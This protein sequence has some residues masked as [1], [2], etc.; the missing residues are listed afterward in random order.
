MKKFSSSAKEARVSSSLKPVCPLREKCTETDQMHWLTY[1]HRLSDSAR[2]RE[3]KVAAKRALE[4]EKELAMLK[5]KKSA[6]AKFVEDTEERSKSA[7]E[8]MEKVR[9]GYVREKAITVSG[10]TAVEMIKDVARLRQTKAKLEENGKRKSKNHRHRNGNGYVTGGNSQSAGFP[11]PSL[12]LG[13]IEQESNGERTKGS[14]GPRSASTS[15][16]PG[17]E[18]GLILDEERWSKRKKKQERI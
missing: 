5:G 10:S 3:R 1:S 7:V 6:H 8:G 4:V 12:S 13:K 9:R 17:A 16:L 2:S 18:S 15:S 11:I 14:P